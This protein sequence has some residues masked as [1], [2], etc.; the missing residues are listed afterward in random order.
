[1]NSVKKI[2]GRILIVDDEDIV[3]KTLKR[4]LKS[5]GHIIDSAYCGTDALKMIDNDYELV[6]CDL[7][8][9]DMTEERDK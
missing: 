6:I 1:M 7:Q 4:L 2:C 8:M 3:H 9:P 5:Q